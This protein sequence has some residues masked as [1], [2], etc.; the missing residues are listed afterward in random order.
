[1]LCPLFSNL[2]VT[3]YCREPFLVDDSFFMSWSNPWLAISIMV[4]FHYYLV[5][6]IYASLYCLVYGEKKA[7]D[8]PK[9]LFSII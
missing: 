4:G 8:A 7:E 6:S 2:I 3:V 9:V 1:M 5:A